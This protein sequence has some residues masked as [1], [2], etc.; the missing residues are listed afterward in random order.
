MHRNSI[1]LLAILFLV[2]VVNAQNFSKKNFTIV[3]K[4][5]KY[6]KSGKVYLSIN[7][8]GTQF[9][10]EDTC[11]IKNGEF[12]F[13]GLIDEPCMAHLRIVPSEGLDMNKSAPFGGVPFDFTSFMLDSGI[14]TITGL[15]SV[16]C[17]NITGTKEQ[18]Y[19]SKLNHLTIPLEI[20]KDK[21]LKLAK[22]ISIQDSSL[23]LDYMSKVTSTR[24]RIEREI[25]SINL[26][27]I[28]EYPNMFF[29]LYLLDDYAQKN[30]YNH[31]LIRP[32]FDTILTTEIKNSQ[33]GHYILKRLEDNKK[34][35][36]VNQFIEDFKLKDT[37]GDF[38]S[39][40]SFKSRF[41]L[42][43]F[44]ASWCGP[45]RAKHPKLISLY[46][47]YHNKG[48]DIISISIDKDATAWKKAISQDKLPWI[49]LIE[50]SGWDGTVANAFDITF[51]PRNYLLSQDGRVMAIDIKFD[52]LE[53][54]L[55]QEFSK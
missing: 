22:N 11:T 15:D 26:F 53:S 55:N 2:T 19:F 25:D 12:L 34:K 8:Y 9:M 33:M 7:R 21:I 44:W 27:F 39:V 6:S 5:S 40:L 30:K 17:S 32:L 38:Q 54:I 50:Q 16:Y 41:I 52:E 23:Y 51:L 20:K 10:E 35:L 24:S 36:K 29:S 42:L 1:Y 13:S 18:E 45:C 37:S 49:N 28:K 47:S 48:F 14:T 3:G 4:L 31:D 46:N 43:D